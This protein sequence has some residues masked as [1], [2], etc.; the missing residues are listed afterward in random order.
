VFSWALPSGELGGIAGAF[1][2]FA[3]SIRS[4]LSATSAAG[5]VA[6]SVGGT[7]SVASH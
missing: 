4:E 7:V 2:Q 5:G 6:A 1:Y 3:N